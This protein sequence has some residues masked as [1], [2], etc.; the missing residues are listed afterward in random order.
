[1]KSSS[2]WRRL[3]VLERRLGQRHLA[4]SAPIVEVYFDS[5]G[6][7]GRIVSELGFELIPGRRLREV[8]RPTDVPKTPIET[9]SESD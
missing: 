3:E 9:V 4:A 2:L 8:P 7:D 1:M 6:P 5:L